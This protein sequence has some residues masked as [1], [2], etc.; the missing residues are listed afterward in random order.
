[1]TE[2]PD[3]Y[4]PTEADIEMVIEKATGR[5]VKPANLATGIASMQQRIAQLETEKSK[6]LDRMAEDAAD[7]LKDH[8][9]AVNKDLI[10]AR[11]RLAFYQAQ[12]GKQN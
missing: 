2:S 5:P 12:V 9:I 11:E 3:N 4:E 1:M 10:V 7:T 8:L 6:L